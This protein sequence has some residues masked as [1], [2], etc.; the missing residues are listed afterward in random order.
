MPYLPTPE[1]LQA[2]GFT[3]HVNESD[4]QYYERLD[5]ESHGSIAETITVTDRGITLHYLTFVLDT[6]RVLFDGICPSESFFDQLL[7]A[8]GWHE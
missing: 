8:V 1:K 7:T 5:S 6:R 2:L 4:F 3:Q